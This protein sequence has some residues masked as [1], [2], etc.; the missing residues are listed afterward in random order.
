MY[1]PFNIGEDLQKISEMSAIEVVSAML[2]IAICFWVS[3][4]L[5]VVRAK[6]K[7]Q[8]SLLQKL[9]GY[10][11]NVC[12]TIGLLY[13]YSRS[14]VIYGL[15]F[16]LIIGYEFKNNVNPRDSYVALLCRDG[17]FYGAVLSLLLIVTYIFSS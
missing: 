10:M 14:S 2:F 9:L 8:R 17:A 16:L 1:R 15:M 4:Q 11:I 12:V 3:V 5:A 13:L 6:R 7:R